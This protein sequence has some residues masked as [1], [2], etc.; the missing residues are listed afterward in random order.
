MHTN[1]EPALW[2]SAGKPSLARCLK[3]EE[4]RMGRVANLCARRGCSL[5]TRFQI[6]H[7]PIHKRSTKSSGQRHPQSLWRS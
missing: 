2:P 6:K 4:L 3:E 7:T 5:A 1:F